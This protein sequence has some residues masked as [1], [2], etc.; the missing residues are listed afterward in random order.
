MCRPPHVTLLNRDT[1]QHFIADHTTCQPLAL[2]PDNRQVFC[3]PPP[4]IVDY[5]GGHTLDKLV[6]FVE[7]H[8]DGRSDEGE[9]EEG[10]E[11]P[12]EEAGTGHT[13]L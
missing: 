6:K 4:Q 9:E 11:E 13:E 8:K 3:C 12:E 10:G 5:N 7:G 2:G 1:L